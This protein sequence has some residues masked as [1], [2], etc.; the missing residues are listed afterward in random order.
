MRF[1][2][3]KWEKKNNGKSKGNG[4]RMFPEPENPCPSG[5]GRL[6]ELWVE[7][8]AKALWRGEGL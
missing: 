3:E 1:L 6:E 5:A 2:G 8:N 4:F 7:K